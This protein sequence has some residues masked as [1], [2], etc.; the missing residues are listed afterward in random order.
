MQIAEDQKDQEKVV[1]TAAG[2]IWT[3][4][5][6]GGIEHLDEADRLAKKAWFSENFVSPD[7][8]CKLA[9]DTSVLYVRE[10]KWQ[11]AEKYFEK[12]FSL[13]EKAN[14][15]YEVYNRR[16]CHIIYYQ[17]EFFLKTAREQKAQELYEKGRVLA[18]EGKWLRA[19]IF[20]MNRLA[21]IAI[22]LGEFDQALELLKEGL[23]IAEKTHNIRVI[24]LYKKSF[25]ILEQ[26]NGNYELCR[27]YCEEALEYFRRLGMRAEMEDTNEL[28][29][30]IE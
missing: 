28:L 19:V 12:A 18:L 15:D 8:L 3:L 23:A 1:M 13:L 17:A 20:F 2:I 30:M 14:L 4:T 29:K 5:R 7:I 21:D 22:K 9:D 25:A 10:S 27:S 16:K 26:K 11:E 6:M 24:A